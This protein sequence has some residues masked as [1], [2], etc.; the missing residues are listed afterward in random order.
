MPNMYSCDVCGKSVKTQRGLKQHKTLAHHSEGQAQQ[1]LLELNNNKKEEQMPNENPQSTFENLS[2]L[3]TDEKRGL[4]A[5]PPTEAD[6]RKAG[7]NS[8]RLSIVQTMQVLIEI[9][10]LTHPEK[11]QEVI[12]EFKDEPDFRR[13]LILDWLDQ[14]YRSLGKVHNLNELLV[15]ALKKEAVE[16]GILAKDEELPEAPETKLGP[17]LVKLATKIAA[18]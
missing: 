11:M 14:T 3:F 18:S 8:V 5:P 13:I 15:K 4:L 7:L 6:Q 1:S 16:A 9:A 2:K 12:E 17:V 10:S